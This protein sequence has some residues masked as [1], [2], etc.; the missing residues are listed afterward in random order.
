M[1]SIR[2]VVCG[3][4]MA[5]AGCTGSGDD[6]D[7]GSSIP[8]MYEFESAFVPG[9]SS[10]AYTGQSFRQVLIEEMKGRIGGLTARIDG[11][12]FT[13]ASGD[14]REELLFYYGFDAATGGTVPLTLSTTP[15]P[16]QATYADLS[17]S[18]A[19]LVG[20]IA[21]N[22]A[23]AQHV[24]WSTSGSLVGIATLGTATGL[25]FTPES[26]FLGWVD[27]LDAR[28]V[29]W[30]NGQ[31][32]VDPVSGAPLTSVYVTPQGIDLQQIIQK[33]LG[34]AIAF[35]QG[36]DDYL[37]DATPGKGLLAPNTQDGTNPYTVLEHAWDEGFGYFGGSRDYRLLSDDALTAT[38][39]FDTNSD[40]MIDL[41]REYSYGHSVNASKRDAGSATGT[42]FSGEAID[43]F[44]AGRALIAQ[45]SAESR[46]LSTDEL[47]ELTGY[48]DI[49]VL[50]WEKAIGAT[51]VSYINKTLDEMDLLAAASPEY[52]FYA[53]AKGWSEM[54]GFALVLQFNPRSPVSDAQFVTLHGNLRDVPAFETP[55]LAAYETDLLEARALLQTAYGFDSADVEA[56]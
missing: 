16:M 30:A 11:G 22:D 51:I 42:D 49:A 40:S 14:V 1:R 39:Y 25:Q 3:L 27:Q 32:G 50:A 26:L 5:V 56:W 45:A 10:V 44:L 28:A 48:R 41:M 52:D 47:A 7:G 4:A 55:D 18:G 31:T 37:D 35:S 33:F 54:K 17:A 19:N 6:D 13:P 15:A 24:A 36:T 20:K 38:P 43:V 53:H 12:T 2:A 23:D 21:G 8:E 34:G 29:A 9:Q 46:E